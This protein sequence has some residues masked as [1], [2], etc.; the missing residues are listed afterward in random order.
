MKHTVRLDTDNCERFSAFD[1]LIYG[2]VKHTGLEMEGDPIIF[3]SDGFPVYHLANVVDDHHM[4]ISHVL[5]GDESPFDEK[6]RQYSKM[7]LQVLNG[8]CRRPNT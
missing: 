7:I 4:E 2:A 6:Q 5:R 1:D 3:K 8:K